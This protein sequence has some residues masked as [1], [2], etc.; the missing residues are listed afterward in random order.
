MMTAWP[1]GLENTVFTLF[2]DATADTTREFCNETGDTWVIEQGSPASDGCFFDEPGS[3]YRLKI[4]NRG[5]F[6][7][8]DYHARGDTMWGS[9]I[10]RSI[11]LEGYWKVRG[12]IEQ[13]A[14]ELRALG[15]LA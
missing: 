11:G 6:F 5:I 3:Y 15:V 10:D 8:V 4:V 14:T 1:E 13:V 2:P 7:D 12:A 9:T